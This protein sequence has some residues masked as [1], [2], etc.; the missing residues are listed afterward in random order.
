MVTDRIGKT[1]QYGGHSLIVA[2]LVSAAPYEFPLP[3]MQKHHHP[4][5]VSDYNHFQVAD[6]EHPNTLVSQYLKPTAWNAYYVI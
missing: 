5:S 2:Q 6:S 3:V 4:G 1:N